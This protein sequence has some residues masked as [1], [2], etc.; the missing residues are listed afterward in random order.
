[1]ELY[2]KQKRLYFAVSARSVR[3]FAAQKE[4]RQVQSLTLF[5]FYTE[6]HEKKEG[7]LWEIPTVLPFRKNTKSTINLHMFYRLIEL[8]EE[9]PSWI[10]LIC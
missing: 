9:I 2:L 4:S 3:R 1:M 10:D 5:F 6:K 7:A 8:I